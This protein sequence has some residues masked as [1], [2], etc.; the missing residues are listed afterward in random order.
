[1]NPIVRVAATQRKN[2]S[3]TLIKLGICGRIA[4]WKGQL[5]AL[6]ALAPLLSN[7]NNLVLEVL[8]SPLFG[9]EIYFQQV[10]D[11]IVEKNISEK[12]NLIPFC[13]EPEKIM[14]TW[15]L[16]IH[17]AIEPEPFGR[18][19]VE[20]LMVGVPVIVPNV[21]GPLE[22]VSERINGLTYKIGD[23]DDLANK[24]NEFL[25]NSELR[26]ELVSNTGNIFSI[27]NPQQQVAAFE[28]W[29]KVDAK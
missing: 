14:A 29:L 9:D 27:F 19:I 7:S 17:A 25:E 4:E 20:S 28:G 26:K 3:E 22:I 11:F 2:S 12:V 10:K 16:S 8:G 6:K 15:D 5:F 21:G 13:A 23:V 18:T 1:M 24:V